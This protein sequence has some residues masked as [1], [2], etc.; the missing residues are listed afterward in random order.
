MKKRTEQQE[1]ERSESKEEKKDL[2]LIKKFNL[3]QSGYYWIKF[4]DDNFYGDDYMICHFDLEGSMSQTARTF[5]FGGCDV[6]LSEV[7]KVHSYIPRPT[8]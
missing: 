4:K 1:F 7:K 8:P 6:H 2:K 5:H 3:Q